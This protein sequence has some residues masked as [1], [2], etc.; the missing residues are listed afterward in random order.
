VKR[1]KRYHRDPN[2]PIPRQTVWSARFHLSRD[3]HCWNPYVCDTACHSNLDGGDPHGGD[4]DPD[5]DDNDPYG[6]DSVP[7]I[8]DS[9]NPY[10]GD[11][12]PDKDPYRNNSHDDHN[13]SNPY[14]GDSYPDSDDYNPLDCYRGDSDP[15]DDYGPHGGDASNPYRSDCVH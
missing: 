5:R 14:G 3:G 13:P 10:G 7:D 11:S 2:Q 6:G 8:V 15:G 9:S 12:D 4:S 1:R